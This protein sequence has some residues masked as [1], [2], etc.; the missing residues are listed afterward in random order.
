VGISSSLLTRLGDSSDP[1]F[2]PSCNSKNTLMKIFTLPH[3]SNSS[4]NPPSPHPSQPAQIPPPPLPT[5][6]RSALLWKAQQQAQVYP[7]APVR[8]SSHWVKVTLPPER[9]LPRTLPNQVMR[10]RRNLYG[11]WT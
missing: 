4:A 2:C 10:Q 5:L 9:L 6:Q 3:A 1:W 7:T 8:L 11:S